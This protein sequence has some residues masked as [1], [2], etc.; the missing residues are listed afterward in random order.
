M[1]DPGCPKAMCF[2][3]VILELFTRN[4]S[5]N[6]EKAAALFSPDTKKYSCRFKH[7]NLNTPRT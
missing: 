4:K 1:N 2:M 3:R 5:D 6:T 7:T